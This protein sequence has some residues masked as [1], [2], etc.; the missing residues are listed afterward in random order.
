MQLSL[1]DRSSY[2]LFGTSVSGQSANSGI[3]LNLNL[4]LNSLSLDAL[5]QRFM[6]RDLE[7]P[8]RERMLTG[9]EAEIIGGRGGSRGGGLKP[10]Y[11]R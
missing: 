5:M 6:L 4:N 9:G 8:Q 1:G 7:Q 3:D 10:P 2:P 11:H